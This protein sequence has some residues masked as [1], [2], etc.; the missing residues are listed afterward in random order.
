MLLTDPAPLRLRLKREL[1][2]ALPGPAVLQTAL[3]RTSFIPYIER[4]RNRYGNRFTVYPIDMPPLV[5]LA[6]PTDIHAVNTAPATTL[7][8]GAGGSLLAPLIGESSFM[9]REGE[10]HK[11]G[12]TAVIPAFQRKAVQLDA[13]MVAET[14]RAEVACWPRDA[15]LALHPRLHTL[16]LKVIL[17]T[18]FRDEEEY[19]EGLHRRLLG[20]LAV[21][22]G[23]LLQAPVLRHLPG[24]R[25]SWRR[26]VGQHARTDELLLEI[27]RARRARLGHRDLL[28]MLIAAR[29]HD[30][31][32]MSDGQVRDNL[33]SMILA[34]HETTTAELAWAFQLLAHNQGAQ[35]RLRAEID[36]GTDDR[37]LMATVNETLRHRPA[38]PFLIPRVVV[39]PVE[40]GGW[41]YR[42]PAH[43]LA[44]TYLMHHDPSLYPQPQA[45]RPERFVEETP[46]SRVWLPWG[47][48]AKS[49][50]GR[51]FA[52]LGM[53]AVLREVLSQRRVL[54]TG[55]QIERARWR[56][57]VLVPH[58]GCTVVLRGRRLRMRAAAPPG[59]EVSGVA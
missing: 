33:M 44:C 14:I 32:P 6:D 19:Q 29:N 31:A 51:H 17:K 23:A 53:R 47:A 16:M 34:G 43:L 36:A 42:P 9:L 49:C 13:E 8:P 30:G 5:F 52:L 11:C 55:R 20:S 50:V 7:H 45:F 28:D 54:P 39:A 38:F 58:A 12:R 35:N 22:Q 27:I 24:G 57:A 10:Q 46:Q 15:P 25:A 40:I 41:T 48:G 3:C 18:I 1:P 4:C 2:P 37:Y 56:S 26:F 21:T 59:R